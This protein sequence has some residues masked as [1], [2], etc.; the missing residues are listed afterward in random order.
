MSRQQGGAS[1]EGG[2]SQNQSHGKMSAEEKEDIA[3]ERFGKVCLWGL[4]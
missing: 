4:F 1:K 3:Q 2:S